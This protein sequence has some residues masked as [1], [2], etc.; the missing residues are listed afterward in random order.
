MN[1]IKRFSISKPKTIRTK[2]VTRGYRIEIYS[3]ND[4][5]KASEVYRKF[6]SSYPQTAVYLNFESSFFKVRIGNFS[7]TAEGNK[8]LKYYR[9]VYPSSFWVIS[10]IIKN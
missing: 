4:R 10:N 6:K 3:G 9:R 1:K 2:K 8:S 5:N 7:T